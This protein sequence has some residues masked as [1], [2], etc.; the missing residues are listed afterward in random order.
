MLCSAHVLGINAMYSFKDKEP[1]E[2]IFAVADEDSI[3]RVWSRVSYG[4]KGRGRF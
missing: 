3:I 1:V 4:G 2:E